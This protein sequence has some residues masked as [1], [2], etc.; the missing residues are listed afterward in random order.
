MDFELLQQNTTYQKFKDGDLRQRWVFSSLL[1]RS[2][3]FSLC[4]LIWLFPLSDPSALGIHLFSSHQKTSDT[5][6]LNFL[7]N[8]PY[9]RCQRL[10]FLL[11]ILV[12]HGRSCVLVAWKRLNRHVHS[13]R[14]ITIDVGVADHYPRLWAGK[15]QDSFSYSSQRSRLKLT[16][17]HRISTAFNG[18][19]HFEKIAGSKLLDKYYNSHL[20]R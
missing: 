8:F 1:F 18:K 5:S 10:L 13:R 12:R 19:N 9:F 14:E 6:A 2:T 3:E 11:S 17:G 7:I 15:P 20:K 4:F 16:S